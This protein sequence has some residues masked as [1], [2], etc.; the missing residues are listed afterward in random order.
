MLNICFSESAMGSLKYAV[1]TGKLE[2]SKVVCIPDDLSQGD[3]SNIKDIKSRED[4]LF[5]CFGEKY[6]DSNCKPRYA[7]YYNE[8]HNHKEIRIWYGNSSYEFCG[9]LY[10]IWF[11]KNEKVNLK[12]IYCTRTIE[13]EPKTYVHYK[14]AAEISPEEIPIFMAFEEEISEVRRKEYSSL[15]NRLVRENGQL[16]AYINLTISTVPV[17]F[18]DNLI[19]DYITDIPVTIASIIG[20]IFSEED[21]GISDSLIAFRIKELIKSG[22][23]KLDGNDERFYRNHI[24]KII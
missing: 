16:R 2:P 13:R 24:I 10:T 8:I 23:L 11:L 17:S 14:H 3:I 19:V 6:V 4:I 9:M 22:V 20:K 21:L 18:Y 7:E 15:W 5:E 12:L 1:S